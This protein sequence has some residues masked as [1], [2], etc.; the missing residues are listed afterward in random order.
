[1]R[2]DWLERRRGAQR[3]HDGGRQRR[4]GQ[5]QRDRDER[6]RVER[7]DADQQPVQEARQGPGAEQAISATITTW[8]M[9]PT[10]RL[11]SR[12]ITSTIH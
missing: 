8:A 4:A 10:R 2:D 6:P 12:S 11:W 5:E 7:A 3:R 9:S 1:M